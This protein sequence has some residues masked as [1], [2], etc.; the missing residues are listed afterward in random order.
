MMNALPTLEDL[1]HLVEQATLDTDPME[2]LTESVMLSGRL[3]DLGDELV[4]HFVERARASGA[5]WAEIGEGM[6]VSKQAAQKR[7]TVRG[8]RRP[9]GGFFLTRFTDEARHVA[10]RAVAHARESGS[11][12]VGSEH[13]LLGMLDD[14][15]NLACRAITGL[16]GSIE[17]I[18]AA[19]RPV[20]DL[21]AGSS[22]SGHVP[23]SPDA[24]KVLELAL[25]ET[26]RLADRRIGTE[27]ILLAILRDRKS[28]GARIL[29]DHGITHRA[30]EEWLEEA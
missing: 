20:P 14:P 12:R 23:F 16:G 10:R 6:G 25:R 15:E 11:A 21:G 1:V 19:A 7:F 9:G 24:K 22:G 30:V 5:T 27:H 2:Q 29:V 8:L 4:G 17:E 3:T 18:R 28:P 13:V 26:I